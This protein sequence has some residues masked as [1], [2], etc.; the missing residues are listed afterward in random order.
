MNGPKTATANWKTQY[1]VTFAQS[2]LNNSATGTVVTANGADETYSS[3]PH[4]AY[5]DSGGTIT[6]S[7]STT[8]TSSNTGER[9][10]LSSV[11]G[12]ASG[13]SVSSAVTVTGNYVTQYQ[14]S[15]AV[16]PSGSG[17]TSPSGTNVWEDAGQ[18]AVSATPSTG[19]TFSSWASD[20]ASITFAYTSIPSTT[21]TIG[22]PGTITARACARSQFNLY[23]DW[24][25]IGIPGHLLDPSIEV[26]FGGNLQHV[27]AIYGYNS[28]NWT[29]W[30]P[31]IP[32]TLNSLEAGHGYWLQSNSRFNT[33][34]N[35]NIIG[36][37]LQY[38]PGWN[39]IGI[40]KGTEQSVADYLGG[41]AWSSIYGFNSST[42]DWS[43]NING[44]GGPMTMFRPGEGYWVYVE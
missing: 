12:P 27:K 7:Y 26:V 19:Y 29:Y 38:Q 6:Y 4:S 9:F 1:Q 32:S 10:R 41:V 5:V 21:A 44:L 37:P 23:Q 15:F 3:L 30:I 35:V 18:L 31:G 16:N 13:S 39:L 14:I 2:G 24:N 28:G 36:E 20:T 17:S 43:Y 34:L 8:V 11:S 22:G 33:T 40:T 42:Q 25:L